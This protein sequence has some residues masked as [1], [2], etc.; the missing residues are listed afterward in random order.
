[1][2][3][4]FFHR[5]ASEDVPKKRVSVESSMVAISDVDIESSGSDSEWHKLVAHSRGSYLFD[6]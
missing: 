1:M 5:F 2:L 3:H 4:F 6:S